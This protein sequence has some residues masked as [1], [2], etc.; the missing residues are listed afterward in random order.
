M[1]VSL[2]DGTPRR[3]FSSCPSRETAVSCRST[4]F[5]T[6]FPALYRLHAPSLF[7]LSFYP[8]SCIHPSSSSFP[9]F[10]TILKT[11]LSSTTQPLTPTFLR[12]PKILLDYEVSSDRFPYLLSLI[13]LIDQK[14]ISTKCLAGVAAASYSLLLLLSTQSA[15]P[16]MLGAT[17]WA[18]VS[19]EAECV[20]PTLGC[21]LDVSGPLSFC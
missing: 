2:W 18:L 21:R 10:T 17:R 1:H 19:S 16:S 11:I 7:H 20:L 14:W 9:Q 4:L 15:S 5:L 12:F 13:T 8:I 3:G 6:L